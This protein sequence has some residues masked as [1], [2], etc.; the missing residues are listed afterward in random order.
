MKALYIVWSVLLLL[1]GAIYAGKAA[2]IAKFDHNDTLL[3]ISLGAAVGFIG[4]GA[5]NLWVSIRLLKGDPSAWRWGV[6]AVG[7]GLMMWSIRFS[8]MIAGFHSVLD[9]ISDFD[10]LYAT[11][12]RGAA[13]LALRNRLIGLV[14]GS[15]SILG[16]TIGL[17]W[18]ETNRKRALANAAQ[19]SLD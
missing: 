6:W 18:L 7:A 16:G 1:F 5:W 3:A 19:S 17:L 12:E 4:I 9:E 10:R 11:F 15:Y 14:H 13:S 2:D 8:P